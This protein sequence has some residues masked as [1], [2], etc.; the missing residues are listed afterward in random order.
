MRSIKPIFRTSFALLLVFSLFRFPSA[1]AQPTHPPA[2]T[3]LRIINLLPILTPKIG[4]Y[5]GS[6]PYLLGMKSGFFQNYLPI[7]SEGGNHFTVKQGEV[8]IG[9]FAIPLKGVDQFYTLAIFQDHGKSP[10]ISFLDDAP[11]MKKPTPEEPN[12]TPEPRL[13]LYIGGYDF[14]IKVSAKGVGE[15]ITQDTTLITEKEIRS[16]LPEVVQIDYTDKYGQNISLNFPTDYKSALCYSAFI[17][18]RAIKRPR[19]LA[20]PDNMKPGDDPLAAAEESSPTPAPSPT[21]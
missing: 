5:R 4:I 9:N 20:Y 15:W 2:G 21:P 18:Q 14:P 11:P 7:P 16:Q 17:T 10:S 8:V 3:Y 1:K 19:I 6:T 12:P 13:R